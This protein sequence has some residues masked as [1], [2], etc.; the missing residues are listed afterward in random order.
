VQLVTPD[1]DQ[2]DLHLHH[3]LPVGFTYEVEHFARIE[4]GNLGRPGAVS[5]SCAAALEHHE[6]ARDS[7]VDG[8]DSSE[9]FAHVLQPP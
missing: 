1:L 6:P 4:C 9:Q 5:G 8:V 3:R 2:A 7:R